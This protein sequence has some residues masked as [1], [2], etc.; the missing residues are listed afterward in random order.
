MSNRSRCSPCFL[1]D[2]LLEDL[3][4]LGEG[5]AL[6][7][8]PTDV[9]EGIILATRRRL[10]GEWENTLALADCSS[11]APLTVTDEE[12]LAE[13]RRLADELGRPPMMGDMDERGRYASGMCLER[14]GGWVQTLGMAGIDR[15]EW[16]RL[17][18]TSV[19]HDEWCQ[20]Y[21]DQQ[22]MWICERLVLAAG[23][24]GRSPSPMD[25]DALNAVS[26][27]RVFAAFGVWSDAL[28]AAGLDTSYT[29]DP[30]TDEAEAM[31]AD[32]RAV[33]GGDHPTLQEY[34]SAGNFPP[35][36]IVQTFGAWDAAMRAAR[37]GTTPERP[38]K[39]DLLGEIRWLAD[40]LGRLPLRADMNERGMY[41]S[42]TY[43][44]RFDGWW[45]A[46]EK[47]LEVT[48]MKVPAPSERE[49]GTHELLEDL[50]DM[51]EELGR[52]PTKA[53]AGE[54]GEWTP[55][56]YSNRFGGWRAALEAAGFDPDEG[57]RGRWITEE[58]AIDELWRLAVEL[59]RIPMSGDM[60]RMGEF[61][62][63]QYDRL[64]GSWGAALVAAGLFE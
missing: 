13:V 61:S 25:V 26:S 42:F 3:Q 40:H 7:Q 1:R 59:D 36:R 24:L 56:T 28:E 45:D 33:G 63:E 2:E 8:H 14:F 30:R 48:E 38:P 43:E 37:A 41:T 39:A 60:E 9:N 51:A 5:L 21:R 18:G 15:E 12:L 22:H 20:L 11:P 46:V 44:R 27:S 19:D 31:V 53:E 64:F 49:A 4:R 34:H 35:E 54:L 17:W 23:E 10:F 57:R 29:P 6:R 62:T 47:A 50:Q 52:P 58:E 32:I 55:T 16:N